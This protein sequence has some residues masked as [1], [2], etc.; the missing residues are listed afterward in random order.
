MK[1]KEADCKGVQLCRGK[2]SLF[3]GP[4][5]ELSSGGR[6]RPPNMPMGRFGGTGGVKLLI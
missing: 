6:S 2:E 1:V 3:Y 5:A 4:P